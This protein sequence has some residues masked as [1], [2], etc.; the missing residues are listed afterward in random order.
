MQNFYT[1]A[2]LRKDGSPY[3]IGKGRGNRAWAPHTRCAVQRP[4]DKNRI[5]L[6]K[7][8]LSEAEAFQHEKYLIAVLGRKDLGTGIL[9]NMTNGGEGSSGFSDE[10]IKKICKARQSQQ[11]PRK[12]SFHSEETKALYRKQRKQYDYTFY[13]PNGEIVTDLSPTEMCV[14]YPQLQRGNLVAVARGSKSI[15]KGWKASRVK[16]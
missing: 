8:N 16:V 15:H 5:L 2:Y 3:Y 7:Q 14:L 10:V 9:R 6:L 13:G 4:K 11:C 1:Y 12:N